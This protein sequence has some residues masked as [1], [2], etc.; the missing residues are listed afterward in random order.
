MHTFNETHDPA[1]RSWVG[2][3]NAAD[4]DFP[5]Q[6]LPF[7]RLPPRRT[8]ASRSAAASRSATR[9]STWRRR[10]PAGA[11]DG[12]RRT[13]GARRCRRLA[14]R[15]D[16][17]RPRRVVG[18]APRA[19]ACACAK[20]RR[21]S[22]TRAPL[23]VAQDERRVRGAG[24]HRRLH[25]LLHR[26]SITRP[27]SASQ[28]RP[29]NPLLPNYKWVPIGY[30]GRARPASASRGQAFARPIG[31]TMLPGADS[32]SSFGPCQRLDYELEIGIF[33]GRGNRGRRADRDRRGRVACVRHL[34]A[35]RL[36]GA[37]HPGLGVPAARP[38]P[39]EEL[40][41]HD[42]A[43]DRDAGSAR[44]LSASPFG[45]AAGRPAAAAL[46]RLAGQPGAGCD[47]PAARGLLQTPRM[48]EAEQA[49]ARA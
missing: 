8:R 32:A 2:S 12:H 44:A 19:V 10:R 13:G 37:R 23:L 18:A 14:Q 7:A 16:G 30:H 11:F 4:A 15:L 39:V 38:V 46:P 47:R 1:L 42:L 31:Q 22:G 26:R 43:V 48:R 3:A 24:A 35:Q 6:N 34:P 21:P 49:A 41:D 45:R 29:D 9:S 25:R 33:I 20:A 5:I 27:T 17:A 36:V 28:F 40:R